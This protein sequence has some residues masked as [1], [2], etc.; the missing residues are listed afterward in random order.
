MEQNKLSSYD[1]CHDPKLFKFKNKFYVNGVCRQYYG[2]W[3]LPECILKINFCRMCCEHNIGVKH[4][5]D[6]YRC[7]RKCRRQIDGVRKR[8]KTPRAKNNK[9]KATSKKSNKKSN[10][11]T[12][13]T[14]GPNKKN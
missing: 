9:I 12:S 10:R 2:L 8:V 4:A 7:K 1:Q 14:I 5:K 6:L 11:K 13:K 3:G